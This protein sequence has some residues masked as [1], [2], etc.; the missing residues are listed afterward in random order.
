MEEKKWETRCIK[1]VCKLD[2]VGSGWGGRYY[3]LSR[4]S[5]N[6]IQNVGPDNSLYIAPSIAVCLENTRALL[7]GSLFKL[8]KR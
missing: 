4:F 1:A 7:Y 5:C 3:A 6:S 2:G 8:Y